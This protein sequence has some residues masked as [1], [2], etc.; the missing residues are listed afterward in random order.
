M[1]TAAPNSETQLAQDGLRLMRAFFKLSDPEIRSE[2]IEF[3]EN[4]A[5]D[6]PPKSLPFKLDPRA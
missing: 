6:A 5:D 2:I 3:A 4:R 1:D